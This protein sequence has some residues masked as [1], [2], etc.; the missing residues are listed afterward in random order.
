MQEVSVCPPPA[1]AAAA[2]SNA[3]AEAR[4]HAAAITLTSAAPRGSR[5]S[6]RGSSGEESSTGEELRSE[7]GVGGSSE[8][9]SG[10][11]G[12][13]GGEGG[14]EEECS[15][16]DLS[17][18]A[19]AAA[20]GPGAAAMVSAVPSP[21][22]AADYSL[23]KTIGAADNPVARRL[24]E[25][26]RAQHLAQKELNERT[27]PSSAGLT[28]AAEEERTKLR[29]TAVLMPKKRQ[30]PLPEEEE[31]AE[32]VPTEEEREDA[33]KQLIPLEFIRAKWEKDRC[34]PESNDSSA[35]GLVAPTNGLGREVKKRRLDALL[36]QKFA[37]TEPAK[38]LDSQSPAIESR[39][40]SGERRTHR[41]KQS[42]PTT[43]SP[44]SASSSPPRPTPATLTLRPPSELMGSR[45]VG[46]ENVFASHLE[47]LREASEA[48]ER[49]RV[50][51]QQEREEKKRAEEE[52]SKRKHEQESIKGQILQLQLAQAALLSG[53]ANAASAG[54]PAG[55][56]AAANPLLYGYYAHVL[57]SLQSQQQKLVDQLIGGGGEEGASN[58][59]SPRL[60]PRSPCRSSETS[61]RVTSPLRLPPPPVT[62]LPPLTLPSPPP[63]AARP[64]PPSPASSSA[65]PS[66][67]FPG[68]KL[69]SSP[70]KSACDLSKA[71]VEVSKKEANAS[72]EEIPPYFWGGRGTSATGL[73]PQLPCLRV[74]ARVKI[75][76]RA[77]QQASQR[78]LRRRVVFH[79]DGRIR[80]CAHTR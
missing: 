61:R 34:S 10:G 46:A 20:N 3:S 53:A 77:S 55:S 54:G 6:S 36:T 21:L 11:G 52:A 63:T 14:S 59:A 29:G 62:S 9:V 72:K 45:G 32:A 31:D 42:N 16:M 67:L 12:S 2:L 51:M 33:R 41:R 5:G 19:V 38:E 28:H 1:V 75:S 69:P 25:F 49:Q 13:S 56:S 58:A 43:P 44:P 50:R 48:Q 37:M 71:P 80:T 60:S 23:A 40:D 26:V 74:P 24:A 66:T 7:N 57:Q 17:S 78:A 73:R 35:E 15:P 39:R 22:L 79:S 8:A 65:A 76:S 70:M 47:R 68:F 27:P 18:G 4:N 30:W 64:L